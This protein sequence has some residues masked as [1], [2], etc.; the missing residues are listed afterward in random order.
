[1][2]VQ[3]SIKTPSGLANEQQNNYTG[4]QSFDQT[5]PETRSAYEAPVARKPYP[6]VPPFTSQITPAP[7]DPYF[8]LLLRP[9]PNK[10][11][12]STK[13]AMVI[14]L[15]NKDKRYIGNA[16]DLLDDKIRLFYNICY[17]N[18]IRLSQFAA[19]FPRIFTKRAKKYYLHYISPEN[20]FYSAYMK[21]KMH[22]DTNVNHHHYYTN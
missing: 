21:I 22:F 14:K 18:E 2:R 16:Y 4:V 1:M 3:P 12:D 15:W 20:D 7:H 11:L 13:A 17:H 8:D 19:V 10:R 9:I 6:S 5:A